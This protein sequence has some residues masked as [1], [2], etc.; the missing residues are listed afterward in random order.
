MT[1]FERFSRKINTDGPVPA[2]RPGLG[3]CWIFTDGADKDGY[4]V[5]WVNELH[6]AA[7]APRVAYELYVGPIP[8]GLTIDHLCRNRICVRPDHLEPVPIRINTLRGNGL[9]AKNAV[10]THCKNGHEF[11]PETTYIRSRDGYS[12]QCKTCIFAR[13]YAR[14]AALRAGNSA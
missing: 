11:T 10:A 4:G 6:R 1:L 8:G 12:R 2:H 9:S 7:R 3:K 14:R 13:T 5:F